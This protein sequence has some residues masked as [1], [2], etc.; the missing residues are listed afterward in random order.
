MR[1]WAEIT[2]F[3]VGVAAAAALLIGWHVPRGR[4]ELGADVRVSVVQSQT[5]GLSQTGTLLDETHLRAG[6][7]SVAAVTV[8]NPGAHQVQVAVLSEPG[9]D[10]TLDR[11]LRVDVTAGK[12]RVYRGR[13]AAFARAASTPL[14][15]PAGGSLRVRVA[16][17][18]PRNADQAYAGRSTQAALLFREGP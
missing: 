17:S 12:V 3:L 1:R 9:T 13:L 8:S 7:R 14:T 10:R 5:L 15:V 11:I 18:L 6:E 2:S 4:A 16:V